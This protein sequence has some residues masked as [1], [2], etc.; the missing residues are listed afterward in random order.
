MY[1]FNW[2]PLCRFGNYHESF[3]AFVTE[4]LTAIF[5]ISLCSSQYSCF[6]YDLKS[7]VIMK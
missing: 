3:I 4:T 2:A 6:N 7:D 5:F 1:N